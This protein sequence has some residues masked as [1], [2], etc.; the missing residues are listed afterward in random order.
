MGLRQPSKTAV[1][2]KQAQAGAEQQKKAR[3]QLKKPQ[4]LGGSAAA[5]TSMVAAQ[6]QAQQGATQQVQQTGQRAT[7]E[8]VA[9]DAALGSSTAN[10]IAGTQTTVP[11]SAVAAALGSVPSS[12]VAGGEVKPPETAPTQPSSGTRTAY[13]GGI[14]G[15]AGI[16]EINEAQKT[17]TDLQAKFDK[18]KDTPFYTYDPSVDVSTNVFRQTQAMLA[19]N[20]ELREIQ[21]SIDTQKNKIKSFIPSVEGLGQSGDITAVDATATQIQNN[22]DAITKQRDDINTALTNANVEDTKK[23]NDEKARL[24]ALLKTYQEKLSKENL[25]QIAGQSDLEQQLTEREQLLASEGQRVAKL[26]S[27]FG[28]GW[29]ARRY[30]GLS[31]QIY[32]KDLEAIQEGAQAGLEKRKAAERAA[33]FAEEEYQTTLETGKKGYEEKIKGAEDRLD[34]LK[35][36]PQELSGYTKDELK[37]IFNNDETLVNRLFK[38]DKDG[39]VVDTKVSET[40]TALEERLTKL[41]TEKE[42]IAGERTTAQNVATQQFDEAKTS[43]F[44]SADKPNIVEGFK[45]SINDL[46]KQAESK[47]A[48]LESVLGWRRESGHSKRTSTLDIARSELSKSLGRINQLEKQARDAEKKQDTK[49]LK[50]LRIEIG[51]ENVNIQKMRNQIEYA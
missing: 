50:R 18:L 2:F 8:L 33:D 36:T 4:A 27:I 49:E 48:G 9:N 5:G 20:N 39:K 12:A 32:G 37:K 19:R 47:K 43:I 29:N 25:G 31:S 17:I 45:R 11:S 23:L 3:E 6:T 28:P 42:K 34:I 22:I 10:Y 26:A 13:T 40:R 35:K 16:P 46:I 14:T 1:F 21:T 7:Q 38:F 41:G 24:D 30:G 44:G 51:K 15:P